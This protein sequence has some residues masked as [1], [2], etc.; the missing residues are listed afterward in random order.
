[1]PEQVQAL[2]PSVQKL[3]GQLGADAAAGPGH[4]HAL[5]AQDWGMAARLIGQSRVPDPPAMMTA[6]RMDQKFRQ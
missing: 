3:P 1:M 4:Q 2:G 6:Y 5:A